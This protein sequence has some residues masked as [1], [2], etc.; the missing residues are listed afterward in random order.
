MCAP[1]PYPPLGSPSSR[2]LGSRWGVQPQTGASHAAWCL[3]ALVSGC[4]SLASSRP[5]SHLAGGCLRA[6]HPGQQA[7]WGPED[8]GGWGPRP[9]GGGPETLWPVPR[10][11]APLCLPPAAPAPR[12][13]GLSSVPVRPQRPGPVPRPD[14]REFLS[15]SSLDDGLARVPLTGGYCHSYFFPILFFE[16]RPTFCGLGLSCPCSLCISGY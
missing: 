1:P 12:A 14:S 4:P 10:T 15:P 5:G 3:S 6:V 16:G 2:S 11:G 13:G 9:R 8:R 7:L